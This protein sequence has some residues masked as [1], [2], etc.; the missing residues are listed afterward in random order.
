MPKRKCKNTK[1]NSQGKM[2]PPELSHPTIA[3]PECSNTIGSLESD[4]KSN[5]I[6][7]IEV[8]KER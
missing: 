3:S 2:S 6:M 5:F 7:M 8:L 4:L 1:N